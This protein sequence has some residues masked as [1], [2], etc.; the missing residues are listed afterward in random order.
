MEYDVFISYSRKDSQTAEKIY[1]SLEAAGV[2]CFI[3]REDISGGAD[4]PFILA[5]AIM[6]SKILLLVASENAYASEFTQKELTFA[7]SNKGSRFIFPLIVDGSTLP[8]KLEFLLSDINWRQLSAHYRIE[9]D[10]VEDILAKLKD[11]HA[12]ETLRQR[13]QK[14]ARGFFVLILLVILL[15]GGGL[16]GYQFHVKNLEKQEQERVQAALRAEQ[17]AA[18][19]DEAKCRQLLDSCKIQLRTADALRN[20]KRA[21]DTFEEEVATLQSVEPLARRVDTIVNRYSANY[22]YRQLFSDFSTLHLRNQM[23]HKLD[24]MFKYWNRY[25]VSNYNDYRSYPNKAYRDEALECAR[26]ALAIRPDDPALLKIQDKLQK[27][28]K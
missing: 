21:F 28:K 18:K 16:V 23:T 2:H 19:K 5:D 24:S 8:K 14:S 26:R 1:D 11:P 7:V 13:E 12:G 10:L 17:E 20:R 22:T 15:G 4:F 9:T 25:A 6:N 27:K 3:D